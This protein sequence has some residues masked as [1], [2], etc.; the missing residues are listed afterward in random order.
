MS[1]VLN[2]AKPRAEANM[3]DELQIWWQEATPETQTAVQ[4][5]CII[6]LALLGGQFMAA[7]TV[8]TL[9]AHRF[10]MALRLPGAL[11]QAPDAEPGIT[12]TVIAGHLV[13]LTCWAFA[14]WWLASH[15]GWPDVAGRLALVISRTWAL[16]AV[17]VATLTFGGLLAH[18]LIACLHVAAPSAPGNATGS[19]YRGV[20]GMVAAGAY[21]FVVLLALL[22][23]ADLFDWPLT[24]SSAQA[25]WQFSQHLLIAGAALIVGS[26]G[27]RWARDLSTPAAATP[28]QQAGQFTALGIMAATTVLAVAVMLSSAGVLIGLA[29]LAVLGILL[30][31]V[32]G[33]VPDVTAGLQLRSH[34][35]REVWF[36]GAAWQL[37]QIGF[38][39]TQIGRSGDFCRVQNRIVL[40][41]RLHGS[42]AQAA[43]Q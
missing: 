27:A 14:A 22:I 26:L 37:V 21:V 3:F 30:W 29:A 16:A 41:A 36:D 20:A 7:L 5:G 28:E 18:R 43:S 1:P 34:Q 31:L 38:L 39:T 23:T 6:L 11:P 2:G 13:R 35:V 4:A 17:L 32:R 25:L 9:R 12:P 42:P 33:Y 15:Y 19:T 40:E 8:R 24:R 10:D